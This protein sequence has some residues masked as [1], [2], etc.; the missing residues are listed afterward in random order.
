[1]FPK[2]LL[3]C[4]FTIYAIAMLMTFLFSEQLLSG[5]KVMTEVMEIFSL[6][7][8]RTTHLMI[9]LSKSGFRT[10]SATRGTVSTSLSSQTQ[11]KLLV[12]GSP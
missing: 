2:A 8:W 7:K 5:Q 6:L 3:F 9:C 10:F 1:M 4:A 11:G 12:F